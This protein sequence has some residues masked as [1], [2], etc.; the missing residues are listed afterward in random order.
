MRCRHL[1]VLVLSLA[2]A[3]LLW[4]CG[5]ALAQVGGTSSDVL[6]NVS[7]RILEMVRDTLGYFVTGN[8]LSQHMGT[9]VVNSL[10][11]TAEN[12]A[13]FFAQL[14]FLVFGGV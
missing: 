3:G 12:L 11:T 2:V 14:S 10:A 5:V 13:T 9:E 4:D 7:L 8:V 1:L 6:S